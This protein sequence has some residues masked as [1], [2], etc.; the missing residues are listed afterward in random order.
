MTLTLR[1]IVLL[2]I[3]GGVFLMAN[4]MMVANWIS[5]TK[6]P[7]FAAHLQD[8]YLTGTAVTIIFAL[9]ILLVGPKSDRKIFGFS[10][11]CPV[12]DKRLAGSGNYCSEC[13]SKV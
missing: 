13:G 6:V 9:L 2:A 11:T 3:I 1:K 7:Q 10:R 5:G 8:H 12:C 4:I